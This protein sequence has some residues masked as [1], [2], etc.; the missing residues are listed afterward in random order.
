MTT[1]RERADRLAAGAVGAGIGLLALMVS[2][3]V[4]QR[5]TE[6]IWG[7][8]A[9]PTV[10]IVSSIL[11]GLAVALMTGRRLSAGVAG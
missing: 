5:L 11:I 6:L 10:A 3:L 7:P 1:D 8:P 4:G 9:G 2:W